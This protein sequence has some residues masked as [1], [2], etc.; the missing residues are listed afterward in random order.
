M[1]IKLL[2]KNPATISSFAVEIEGS[3]TLGQVQTLLQE[4]YEGNPPPQHQT[5]KKR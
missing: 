2:I 1:K 3:A 5:V 4:R